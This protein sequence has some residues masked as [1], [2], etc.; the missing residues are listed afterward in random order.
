MR[1]MAVFLTAALSV[2]FYFCWV[3]THDLSDLKHRVTDLRQLVIVEQDAKIRQ[4][5][6]VINDI[7]NTLMP[8]LNET[9]NELRIVDR[10][11]HELKTI[12]EKK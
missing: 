1:L 5:E 4:M 11:I 9:N 10:E 3:I 6:N 2:C 12:L 8:D 7:E